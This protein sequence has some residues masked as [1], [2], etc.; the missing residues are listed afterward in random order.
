MIMFGP[1]LENNSALNDPAFLSESPQVLYDEGRFSKVPLIL[2]VND[3]EGL[4]INALR[5]S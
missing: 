4:L 2:S 5:K 1:V 3:V